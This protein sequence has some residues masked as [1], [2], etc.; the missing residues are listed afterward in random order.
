MKDPVVS[1]IR[2]RQAYERLS[3]ETSA[4]GYYLNPDTDFVRELLSGMLVNEQRY[5]YD[6]C[7][8]RLPSGKEEE[9]RDII[10][11]CDYRDLDLDDFGQCYCGLY[12]S[13]DVARKK[14]EVGSIPERRPP[15]RMK[16]H[17]PPSGPIPGSLPYPV[18]RCPVCGYL[19]ARGEPPLVCP[20]CKAK[21]DRFERFL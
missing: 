5:G 9:D 2:L 3:T 17:A 7:P 16:R 8:C 20:I 6:A 12:V 13:E 11:P 21:K 10:C 18:W 1:D 19:C 15:D 14:R 4:S